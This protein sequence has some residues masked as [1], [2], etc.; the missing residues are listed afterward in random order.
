M[1]SVN[2]TLIGTKP[3]ERRKGS[4]RQNCPTQILT[5]TD[6][7]LTSSLFTQKANIQDTRNFK[8]HF[9]YQNAS[10]PCHTSNL[11][12]FLTKILLT[13]SICSSMGFRNFRIISCYSSSL[14]KV[15]FFSCYYTCKSQY[16]N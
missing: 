12:N 2:P 16:E 15:G 4:E 14:K 7:W 11:L 3:R 10:H 6:L 5:D 1:Y 9:E 8:V 13:S